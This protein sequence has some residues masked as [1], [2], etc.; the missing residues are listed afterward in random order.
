MKE[1]KLLKLKLKN[2][3][4]IKSFELKPNGNDLK[5]FGDNGAGKTTL[6]DAFYWLLFDKDS[7]GNS[8]FDIKTLDQDNN[9]IHNLEH[10]VSAVI[11]IN[12]KKLELK[13]IYYE[14]WTKKRGSATETFS[15]HTTDY[16]ISD[17][18]VKKSEYD[19][20]INEIIDE[21][22]FKLLTNTSYFNEQLHWEERKDILFN[23]F[24]D[25]SDKEVIE[26]DQRLNKLS[27]VIE[28]R[29]MKEHRKMVKSK[30]KKIN[31][32]LEKIP[33]RID[34]VNNN[35]PDLPDQ[36]EEEI[37]LIIKQFKDKK[38]ELEQKLS[39][40]ENGAEIAEKR[41]Q[42]AEIDTE[43]Q[44]IK[45]EHSQEYE[46]KIAEIKS[47]IEELKDQLSEIKREI[48]N[49]KIELTD[50]KERAK[51]I[52]S[53]MNELRETWQH[54]NS[55]EIEVDDKCP[56]CRQ[57]LPESEIEAAIK[58]A[59]LGKS[60]RL[61]N[62]NQQGVRKK[63]KVEKIQ[64]DIDDLTSAIEELKEQ[65]P[66]L[67]NVKDNLYKELIDLKEKAEAYQDSFQYQKKLKEKE[68]IKETINELRESKKDS[69]DKIKVKIDNTETKINEMQQ[70]LNKFVQYEKGNERI[71]ELSAQEKD[72]AQKY[73][74][75]EH[76][77]Y[78]IEEFNRAKVEL[79]ENKINNNFELASFKLYEEQVN[80]G[81]KDTCE[82]LYKGVPYSSGLNNGAQINVGLDIIRT[83]SKQYG[84]R[85]PIFIDNS[86]SITDIYE[87]ESQMIKLIVSEKDKNLRVEKEESRKEDNVA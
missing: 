6:F 69:A 30:M 51:E 31:D 19:T 66:G 85:A 74:E 64:G 80:G 44:K 20:K 77:L 83:L 22:R 14:K 71:D 25:V 18:P 9:V 53:E 76:Q 87:I 75:F 86:E 3:K 43:L 47:D 17:V 65:L 1:L 23:A 16:Y 63:E 40:I 28:N 27:E 32:D 59:R 56:T 62:I 38:K 39:G 24:G 45:L 48:S 58:K 8:Q 81:L 52:K 79:V 21:E 46:E 10:Q 68:N 60:E 34:E 70:E 12:N 57:K 73:E 2:F 26:S 72:L 41:K 61:E 37:K 13:K 4:G 55:E 49:K 54:V 15:G 82:T 67:E 36:D 35:L 33:V 5:V 7:K 29:S 84:F 11:K 78:L 50:K 42:L